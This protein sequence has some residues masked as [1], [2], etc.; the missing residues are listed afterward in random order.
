MKTAPLLLPGLALLLTACGGGG[1]GDNANSVPQAHAP[2]DPPAANLSAIAGS[3]QNASVTLGTLINPPTRP[4]PPDAATQAQLNLA[5]AETNRLRAEVGQPPLTYNAE[6]AAY[7]S[8]RAHEISTKFEHTRPNGQSA[9]DPDLFSGYGMIGE[10]LAMGNPSPQHTVSTQWRN[11]P[12]HYAAIIHPDFSR[13][14]MGYY[15]APNSTYKH[16]WTQIFAGGSIA[17]LY[18]FLTPL[19]QST[20]LAAAHNVASYDANGKL[21]LAGSAQVRNS[22]SRNLLS[23]NSA[24]Y[25]N[26]HYL[27]INDEHQ[28]IL[29]AH[30][31]AGWSYQTFGEIADMSGIPEAYV[32]LGQPFVPAVDAAFQARYQG[33]AIGDL[34]QHS[35]V[36]ADVSADVNFSGASKT[37]NLTVNN[38]QRANRDLEMQ[39]ASAFTR[40]SRL[41][42][43]DTL[44]WNSASAQFESAGGNARLYGDNAAELGGQFQRQVSAENYRGAYGAS[45]TP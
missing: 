5:L 42:F 18:A 32:N 23:G 6:L 8:V 19:S 17:S 13:L 11:S 20:A 33:K 26:A 12:S 25:R 35:R 30:P 41:D 1:G 16:H 28:L 21:T 22:D 4:A 3:R 27:R 10:N 15:Y 36:I 37:L 38:A 29:R 44:N 24:L 39:Q 40:D 34:G 31:Q 2:V 14:G 7:A 9:V 43:S 45:R